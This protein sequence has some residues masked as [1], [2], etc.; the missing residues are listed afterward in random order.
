MNFELKNASD[1][2]KLQEHC[3]GAWL[4]GELL[5]AD[6]KIDSNAKPEPEPKTEKQRTNQQNNAMH[7]YF[8]LLAKAL[9][10][11]GFTVA[12]VV[13]KPLN[14]S[15]S[16]HT[17][18]EL[19]WRQVQEAIVNKKSTANLSNAQVSEIYREVDRAVCERT[20]GITI[21]FPEKDRGRWGER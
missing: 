16:Q 14:I 10:D 8:E 17:V 6:V 5:S 1:L 4:R 13:K 2:A 12:M 20:N 11:G 3:R 9:N 15:W 21:P 19:L 18:K 7:K